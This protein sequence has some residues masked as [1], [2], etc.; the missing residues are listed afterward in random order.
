MNYFRVKD[1]KG[2]RF[3]F[4]Q[5]KPTTNDE[6][7]GFKPRTIPIIRMTQKQYDLR[8]HVAVRV[9]PEKKPPLSG[10]FDVRLTGGVC[11]RDTEIFGFPMDSVPPALTKRIE[12]VRVR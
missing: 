6:I 7:Q 1:K 3:E 2:F 10:F 12:S 5:L 11:F 8:S 4:T 9:D